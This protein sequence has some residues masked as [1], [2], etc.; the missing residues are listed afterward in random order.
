MKPAL[1]TPR[2]ARY[3]TPAIVAPPSLRAAVP[4]RASRAVVA[5]VEPHRVGLAVL[6]MLAALDNGRL[7]RGV[8]AVFI[9]AARTLPVLTQTAS[10]RGVAAQERIYEAIAAQPDR[11]R[12]P[13][14]LAIAH[15]LAAGAPFARDL[16]AACP[17]RDVLRAL[18]AAQTA[19][20]CEITEAHET[21]AARI[22]AEVLA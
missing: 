9:A 5:T 6:K 8:D 22:V 16:D 2:G 12:V 7:G 4:V 15:E 14:L 13:V 1:D 10:A 17:W 11:S 21:V 3:L 20:G 19:A 18:G